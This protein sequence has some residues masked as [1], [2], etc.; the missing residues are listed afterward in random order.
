MF[1]ERSTAVR[2]SPI[3]GGVM[4]PDFVSERTRSGQ[5]L[6][7]S[8]TTTIRPSRGWRR[9][10]LRELWEYRELLYF[11]TWRDIKVRYKQT[12]IGVAWAVIQPVFLMVLFTV[13]FG[14]IAGIQTGGI[15]YPLFA[16]AA[17]LPWGLFSASLATGGTSVTANAAL[18][19]RVYFPL[20]FLPASI[21]L[22][23]L[24]DFAI[25]SGV[26]VGLMI[27]FGVGPTWTVLTLPL[28][29]FLAIVASL[30]ISFWLSSLDARFRDI[31][32]TIP[33]LSQLWLFATPIIYPASLVSGPAVWVYS[34]NPMVGVVQGF[35]WALLGQ[36]FTFGLAS[37]LSVLAALV[38]F[39]SGLFY[40][41]RVE[42]ML[43]DVV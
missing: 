41:L 10:N 40:F 15:P 12:V 3:R 43:A 1:I 34:L 39:L 28:F 26:L 25:A 6:R 22:D 13:F 11:L 4:M 36:D 9:L 27:Y 8:P 29:I 42:R 21:V 20:I 23:A 24:V 31:H 38:L 14:R 5:A 16:Y 2:P 35:R 33:F 7:P 32:Y 37:W 17:L 18:V 19:T 30:G